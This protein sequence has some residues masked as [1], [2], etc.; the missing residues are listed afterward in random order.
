MHV[1]V[2]VLLPPPRCPNHPLPPPPLLLCRRRL[3]RCR[4]RARARM[5]VRM[6][7]TPACMQGLAC[8]EAAAKPVRLG[9]PLNLGEAKMRFNHK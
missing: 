4:S 3:R 6:Y 2:H 9:P 7:V 5:R 1:R 8:A